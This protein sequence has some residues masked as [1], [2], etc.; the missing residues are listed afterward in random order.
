MVTL[1][2]GYIMIKKGERR[3]DNMNISVK[4]TTDDICACNTC[5]AKNYDGD[6]SDKRVDTLYDVRIGCM[7]SCLCKECLE[8]LIKQ[9]QAAI[10]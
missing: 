10:E 7:V 8:N 3:K 2:T 6:L 1:D 9:A 5:Y 4:P